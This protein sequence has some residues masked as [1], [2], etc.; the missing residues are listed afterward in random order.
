MRRIK[1]GLLKDLLG[2]KKSSEN[3]RDRPPYL[4]SCDQRPPHVKTSGLWGELSLPRI[5]STTEIT[6][7]TRSHLQCSCSLS[8]SYEHCTPFIHL[9]I[10]KLHYTDTRILSLTDIE[11]LVFFLKL[12]RVQRLPAGGRK[13]TRA[14]SK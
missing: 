3:T 7:S 6:Q 8:S 11:I 1:K 13:T 12:C 14:H 5:S 2:I 9:T 4:R 10:L